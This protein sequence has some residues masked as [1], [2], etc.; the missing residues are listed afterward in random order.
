MEGS[1]EQ[2]QCRQTQ[3]LASP[4]PY[5]I[6][7]P[8]VLIFDIASLMGA[9]R[10]RQAAYKRPTLFWSSLSLMLPGQHL[11]RAFVPRSCPLTL[12][13]TL[14]SGSAHSMG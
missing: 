2:G 8:R 14:N 4:A 7:R 6:E 3:S 9:T 13:V 1:R 10:D 11:C 5:T 12:A